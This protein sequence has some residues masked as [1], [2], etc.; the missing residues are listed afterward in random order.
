M[1]DF[2]F[3]ISTV[4]YVKE[5][6]ILNASPHGII[7]YDLHDLIEESKD[8]PGIDFGR[9]K[10]GTKVRVDTLYSTYEF[11]VLSGPKVMVKGG[12]YFR[13]EREGHLSGSTWGGTCI[14]VNWVG[15]DMN[16]EIVYYKNEKPKIIRTSRVQA[17]TVY[18]DGWE[19]S[20]DWPN[21]NDQK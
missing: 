19:Y 3:A 10:P 13:E 12:R 5:V 16:M 15:Y 20:L 9:L 21:H 7:M 17:A 8:D 2:H 4:R 6:F 11:T 14:K 1:F 18:G